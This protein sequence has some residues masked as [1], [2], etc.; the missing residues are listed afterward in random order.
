VVDDLSKAQG[1]YYDICQVIGTVGGKWIGVPW[2]TGGGLVAYRKAWLA[3][4]GAQEIPQD[5]G[6]IPRLCVSEGD[7]RIPGSPS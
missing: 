6:R 3:E 4:A 5:L 1:G 2:C 7:G